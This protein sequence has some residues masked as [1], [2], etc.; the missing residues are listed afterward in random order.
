MDSRQ[1]RLVSFPS[2]LTLAILNKSD[3][4]YSRLQQI[5]KPADSA[6]DNSQVQK[7]V[8]INFEIYKLI[9]YHLRFF[10]LHMDVRFADKKI[11]GSDLRESVLLFAGINQNPLKADLNSMK[12][13]TK[14]WGEVKVWPRL[15][16]A[17]VRLYKRFD[18][19]LAFI[20]VAAVQWFSFQFYGDSTQQFDFGFV[21]K[22]I[23][24]TEQRREQ[25]A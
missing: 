18:A 8:C 5:T 10:P 11:L 22:V 4:I 13:G 21:K 19:I 17:K 2:F 15:F 25:A 6:R 3:E 12:F 9:N 20:Y 1:K 14:I 7:P 24:N 16:I 23:V